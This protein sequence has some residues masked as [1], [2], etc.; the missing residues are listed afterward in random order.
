MPDTGSEAAAKAFLLGRV[1]HVLSLGKWLADA[2]IV[3]R[4]RFFHTSRSVKNLAAMSGPF[5]HHDKAH[6]RAAPHRKPARKA[7]ECEI[8]AANGIIPELQGKLG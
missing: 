1:A 5:R 6:R 2:T 3:N 8:Y 4:V 7:Q